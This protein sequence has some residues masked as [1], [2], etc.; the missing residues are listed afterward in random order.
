MNCFS[1][2]ISTAVTTKRVWVSSPVCRSY[3]L[4]KA[5]RVKQIHEELLMTLN[6]LFSC[7]GLWL[8]SGVLWRSTPIA[9]VVYANGSQH[10]ARGTRKIKKQW[11]RLCNWILSTAFA[12]RSTERWFACNRA[13]T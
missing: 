2:A 13:S 5:S 8:G 12:R 6:N 10:V 3:A 11:R 9:V 1:F 7:R 4:T